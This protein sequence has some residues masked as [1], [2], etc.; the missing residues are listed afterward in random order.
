MT[1]SFRFQLAL[2]STAVM[3]GALAAISVVSLLALRHSL[4]RELNT[5][6]MNVA[7][8]QASSLTDAPGGEMHFHEWELTPDE[9]SSVRDL[10]RYAEVWRSDGVSLLR[11]QYMK[12]DLPLDSARLAQAG[13]GNL[14]W[15]DESWNGMPIRTVYYPLERMG[16]AHAHHV[17]QVAAPLTGRNQLLNRVGTFLLLLTVLVTGATFAGSWW[18]AGRAVRP[19]NEVID[20]AEAIGAGSLD[21]R[22]RAYA[23]TREYAR[24]VDVINTMLGRIQGAFESQRRFTADA[25]HE[26]RS[27]LTVMRGEMELAL[28]KERGPQEYRQVLT[29]SL[30]E[31]VRLSRITEDL[32]TLARSDSGALR[33]RPEL[34]EVTDAV[35]RVVDRLRPQAQ[36]KGVALHVGGDATVEAWVDPGLLGQV[37]WNLADNAL[38]FTPP[39]GEVRITVGAEGEVVRLDVEDTGPGFGDVDPSNAF[40]RFYRADQARTHDVETAGTGLGLAI[41]KAVAETH[42]GDVEAENRAEGGARVTVRLPRGASRST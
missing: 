3:A 24:M 22:I 9:A 36:E 10:I 42:G 5:S 20:Q 33:A 23:D 39:G 27:P 2:R 13:N 17:L 7:L 32:L 40:R 31:V 30:E 4:D 37:V 29:S 8:I 16:A 11:S 18:L 1:R 34:L 25:S 15:A 26:L 21:R 14:V 6:I 38:K 12:G 28:R 19:V 35:S 41:V